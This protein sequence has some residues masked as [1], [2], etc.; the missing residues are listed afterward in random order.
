MVWFGR[1]AVLPW[2]FN[3]HPGNLDTIKTTGNLSAYPPELLV[4]NV[5]SRQKVAWRTK[6]AITRFQS[7]GSTLAYVLRL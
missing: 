5:G 4:L 1:E 3:C 6:G 7:P 2:M